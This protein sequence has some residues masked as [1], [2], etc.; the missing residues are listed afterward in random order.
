[1][2]GQRLGAGPQSL[3]VAGTCHTEAGRHLTAGTLSANP[4][5]QWENI[6]DFSLIA[7]CRGGVS[8]ASPHPPCQCL[9]SPENRRKGPGKLVGGESRTLCWPCFRAQR[10]GAG[11]PGT[12]PAVDGPTDLPPL[13][14][15]QTGSGVARASSRAAPSRRSVHPSQSPLLPHCCR[16]CRA[17]SLTASVSVWHRYTRGSMPS[18]A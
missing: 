4:W 16:L 12:P 14:H 17:A 5:G 2:A 15:R 9:A 11:R 1:M 3:M 6:L 8:G 7:I 18:G 13:E 10:C